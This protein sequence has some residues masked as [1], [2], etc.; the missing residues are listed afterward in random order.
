[1]EDKEKCLTEKLI[2]EAKKADLALLADNKLNELL[3]DFK[4][5]MED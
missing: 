5:P 2:E 1:M 3:K 4:K